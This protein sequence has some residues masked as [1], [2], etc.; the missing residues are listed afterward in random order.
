MSEIYIKRP[1]V[2]E[3]M[4]WDGQ[5]TEAVAEFLKDDNY[6]FVYGDLFV[7]GVKVQQGYLIAKSEQEGIRIL[8]KEE[9]ENS[10][11][12]RFQAESAT[13]ST[14]PVA[15]VQELPDEPQH[16]QLAMKPNDQ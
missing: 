15:P 11:E 9:L 1:V 8:T 4:E 16:E 14:D 12:K 2:A 10:Y 5:N 7:N 3:V 6:Y 13:P